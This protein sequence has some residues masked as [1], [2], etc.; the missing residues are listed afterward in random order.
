MLLVLMLVAAPEGASCHANAD[1]EAGLTC[2][3]NV[4]AL[5]GTGDSCRTDADC[6]TPLACVNNACMRTAEAPVAAPSPPQKK[7]KARPAKPVRIP[8]TDGMPIP[9]GGELV[10]L[11]N[12]GMWVS[13]TVIL[14]T[15]V[16]VT[17]IVTAQLCSA[18]CQRFVVPMSWVPLAGPIAN[19]AVSAT[20]VLPFMLSMA[21]I[22]ATGV[23]LLLGGVLSHKRYIIFPNGVGGTF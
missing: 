9:P 15:S 5:M 10:E 6:N 19:S 2:R 8:Y 14:A 13:G 7:L 16:A 11:P 21:V 20:E 4:C 17:G 3:A 1:C 23:G 22:Q 18:G 12:G